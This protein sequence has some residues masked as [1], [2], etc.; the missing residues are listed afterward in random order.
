VQGRPLDGARA[1]ESEAVGVARDQTTGRSRL[2][3]EQERAA[4]GLALASA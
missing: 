4:F 2:L 3:T 1:A